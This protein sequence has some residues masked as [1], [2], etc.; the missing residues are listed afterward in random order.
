MYG[1]YEKMSA[2]TLQ[3]Q[4]WHMSGLKYNHRRLTEIYG[5]FP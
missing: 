5:P 2:L 1:L 4:K 3:E